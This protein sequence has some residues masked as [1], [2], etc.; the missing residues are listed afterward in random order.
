MISAK[1]PIKDVARRA[2]TESSYTHLLH[3]YSKVFRSVDEIRG[4]YGLA[5]LQNRLRLRRLHNIYLGKRCFIIANGPSLAQTDLT[6]LASEITIGSNGLFLIFE[7]M[8][9][10]PTFY[11]VQ[12]QLVAE[13]FAEQLNRINGTTKL[14]AR[15]LTYCLLPDRDT[16]YFDLRPDSYQ[17]YLDKHANDN[18]RPK[19]SAHLDKGAYDGCTVTYLNLQL[20]YYIGCREVYLLGLDHEY[21]LPPN[22]DVQN[23][24]VMTSQSDDVSHFH[25]N[26]FGKGFRYTTPRVDKM[27][28]AYIVAREFAARKGVKI[29]NATVGGRLE[30]FPRV[31]LEDIIGYRL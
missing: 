4:Q 14:F 16:V 8:G 2:L 25:P 26:Y 13:G 21:Q 20:A 3:F 31:R 6:C 12:D 22:V 24:I 29:L 23:D 7:K 30:V 15:E 19:F 27:E 10:L 5:A 17:R 18:F 1:E 11:T 28:T 9:Y